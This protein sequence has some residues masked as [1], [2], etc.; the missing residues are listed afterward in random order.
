MLGERDL[1]SLGLVSKYAPDVAAPDRPAHIVHVAIHR[2]PA[3][4]RI[5]GTIYD[6]AY[7]R[8][9][10]RPQA[11]DARFNGGVKDTPVAMFEQVRRAA[12]QGAGFGMLEFAARSELTIGATFH[13]PAVVHD[14]AAH[15][16]VT[17]LERSLCLSERFCHVHFVI[18]RVDVNLG[19]VKRQTVRTA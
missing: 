15:R 14:H 11:H 13:D 5:G 16:T 2:R 4:D 10:D 1:K 3:G 9:D 7:I 17:A 6:I 8:H 19:S 12:A 18:N